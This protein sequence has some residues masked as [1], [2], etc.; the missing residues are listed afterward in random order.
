MILFCTAILSFVWRTGSTSD[1]ATPSSLSPTAAQGPRIAV[2][3]MFL[4]GLVYFLLIVHTLRRYGRDF[5]AG[6]QLEGPGP[7][8]NEQ[9]AD[10]DYQGFTSRGRRRER[11]VRI[12][13]R[14]T[15]SGRGTRSREQDGVRH[16]KERSEL[17][18]LPAISGLGL[19]GLQ[20]SP[21]QSVSGHGGS[22]DEMT[23]LE[24]GE[25][26]TSVQ[27]LKSRT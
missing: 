22:S 8:G 6:N 5:P 25:V 13:E 16:T 2:T 14:R 12:G 7:A 27:E 21:G 17:D 20:D 11:N 1:P 10:R 18:R 4:L 9:T 19:V 23:K 26:L 15:E 3:V 24:K